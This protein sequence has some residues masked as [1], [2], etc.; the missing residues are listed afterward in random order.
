M[1][2]ESRAGKGSDPHQGGETNQGNCE[3][4]DSERKKFR[5]IWV[6]MVDSG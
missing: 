2:I 6:V 1:W 4:G 3:N 5:T